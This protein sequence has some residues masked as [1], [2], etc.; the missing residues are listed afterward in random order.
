MEKLLNKIIQWCARKLR[1]KNKV[2]YT[3]TLL[4][5]VNTEYNTDRDL[6]NLQAFIHR[7]G[8]RKDFDNAIDELLCTINT[9][10]D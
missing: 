7:Q 4:E 5:I 8:Y 10:N 1:K 3:Y 2:L 6:S 9:K